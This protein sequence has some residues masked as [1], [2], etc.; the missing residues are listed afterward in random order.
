M[1]HDLK[2]GQSVV[3][4]ATK[5]QSYGEPVFVPKEGVASE[6]NGW[7]MNQ[8]YDGDRNESFLEIRD[9]ATLEMQA[10]VW[11]GQHLPLGFH[12]NFMPGWFVDE[13]A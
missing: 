2:G 9:A 4:S 7:I 11:T 13:P 6:E 1:R 5:R 8:G 3:A 10:R 12:G